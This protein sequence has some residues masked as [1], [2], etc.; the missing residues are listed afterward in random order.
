MSKLRAVVASVLFVGTLGSLCYSQE[1]PFSRRFFTI[2]QSL[3][4]MAAKVPAMPVVGGAGTV[5]VV[6]RTSEQGGVVDIRSTGGSPEMQH[7]SETALSQWQFRPMLNSNGQPSQIF[8]AVIFDFSGDQPKITLPKPM[9]AAQLSPG[10][11]YPCPNALA[12]H[13]SDAVSLC[14]K[15]LDTI[16]RDPRST[17]MERFTALDEYGVALLNSAHKPDLAFQQFT[18]AIE[19]APKGLRPTDAEWAYVYWHRGVAASQTGNET[20]AKQDFA[21][22]NESM[23]L[24]VAAI[25]TTSNAYYRQLEERLA[26][27]LQSPHP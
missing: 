17:P 14:K 26:I 27:I 4:E 21:A 10:L 15:Q 2:S 6:F 19:T 22:A 12:H 9:S 20:Q 18:Q 13:T 3:I 23:R 25:G 24:A 1:L 8:S 5:L 11:G 7:S 16:S